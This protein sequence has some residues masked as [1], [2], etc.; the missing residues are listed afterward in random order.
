MAHKP[1]VKLR[2]TRSLREKCLQR[3]RRPFE[4]TEDETVLRIVE[5]CVVALGDV[6]RVFANRLCVRAKRDNVRL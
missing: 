5:A 6:S 2:E 3:V 1:P 4:A